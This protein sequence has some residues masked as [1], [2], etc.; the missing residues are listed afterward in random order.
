[1]KRFDYVLLDVFTTR[2]FGGNQLA[3]FPDARGL[4]GQ[5]MQ[6]IGNE[7]NLA[8]TT[9]VLPPEDPANDFKVRIFTSQREMP[10]AGHPTIGTAFTLAARGMVEPAGPETVV[11]FEEKV[12]LIPVKIKWENGKAVF[13]QMQQNLPEFGP[14]VHDKK[15]VAD[16]LSLPLEALDES[17]PVEVVSCGVPY[18][19]VPLKNLADIERIQVRPELMLK[20]Q[21]SILDAN[22]YVFTQNAVTDQAH[23]H[24]RMFWLEN[25]VFSEDA[26]T[27]S[28][29]GPLGCYAA[30]YKLFGEKPR[31]EVTNEQ[32]F[33]INRPSCIRIEIEQEGEKITAVKVG[34]EARFMGGGYF[35]ID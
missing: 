32:G 27:G 21:P 30:R 26:A 4:T 13:C 12:G 35:D 17:L 8:E 18:L 2:A 15:Q 24:S 11:R 29:S 6:S 1:M 20:L 19:V 14:V 31:L 28:A 34:G 3:V 10:M 9:F 16:I 5:Q 25:G 33:E 22:I 23:L 7:L